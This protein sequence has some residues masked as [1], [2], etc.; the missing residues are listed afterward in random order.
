VL[1][2]HPLDKGLLLSTR[3]FP[4]VATVGVGGKLYCKN[5]WGGSNVFLLFEENKISSK[6]SVSRFGAKFKKDYISFT[7]VGQSPVD[8]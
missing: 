4:S 7:K 1:L 8:W 5:R 2:G 3:T 6:R